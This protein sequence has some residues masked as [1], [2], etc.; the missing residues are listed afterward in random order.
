MVCGAR[1]VRFENPER[2]ICLRDRKIKVADSATW[3]EG[4]DLYEEEDDE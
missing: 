1:L 2:F 3:F 4:G